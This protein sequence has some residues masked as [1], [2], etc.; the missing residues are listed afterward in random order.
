MQSFKNAPSVSYERS[1]TALRGWLAGRGYHKAAEAMTL[2]EQYHTG[3]RKG[4]DPEFSHQVAQANLMRILA[5]HIREPE[6]ALIGVFLHDTVED[7]GTPE[8]A[9][10]L[11]AFTLD[12]VEKR[13]GPRVREV[14]NR[15]SKVVNG[16][17]KPGVVYWSEMTV[18]P[19]A[20][21]I[22]GTDRIHNHQT[23]HGAFTPE[24]RDSYLDETEELI[25]PMMKA[26]R[27][28]FPDQEPAYEILKLFLHSQMG[29][30]RAMEPVEATKPQVNEGPS[31]G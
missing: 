27:K 17:K 29:L 6:I 23:M 10:P 28:N 4:G 11:P 18:D 24:K 20:S 21:L 19:T 25:L 5:P 9:A 13:F 30:I 3:T 2:A 22:K 15:I 14:V 7:Y 31:P 16:V 8:E 1:R 26:A 12:E